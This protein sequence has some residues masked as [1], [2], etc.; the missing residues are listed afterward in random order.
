MGTKARK[1]LTSSLKGKNADGYNVADEK[2][3]GTA[4]RSG[5]V[6][7]LPCY[8]LFHYF[9]KSIGMSPD[10][11]KYCLL[12]IGC[13]CVGNKF[14]SSLLIRWDHFIRGCSSVWFPGP[15]SECVNEYSLS[16]MRLCFFL[17]TVSGRCTIGKAAC[18]FG[19]VRGSICSGRARRGWGVDG[20]IR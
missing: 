11:L 15:L 8:V 13:S 20:E 12:A 5:Q 7:D 3:A 19:A 10:R 6:K 4:Y 2:A 18:W 16:T 17:P 14:S 1:G 9:Y